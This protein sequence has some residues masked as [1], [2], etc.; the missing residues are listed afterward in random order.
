MPIYACLNRLILLLLLLLALPLKAETWP[1]IPG[2][3]LSVSYN[4]QTRTLSVYNHEPAPYSLKF[5]FPKLQNT[6]LSCTQPCLVLV[7]PMSTTA[8]IRLGPAGAGT[9]DFEYRYTSQI[10][11]YRAVPDLKYVYELPYTSGQSY[12]LSQGYNGPF[13]HQGPDRYALDFVMPEGT[14][15]LAAR[16]GTVVW[17]VSEYQLGG[18]DPKFK[19]HANSVWVL[20]SDGTLAQYAHLRHH[21]VSVKKGQQVQAGALLG[22]SGSTGYSTQPHLH[23]EVKRNQKGELETWPT[24]F[25]TLNGKALLQA[26]TRYQR[27]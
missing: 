21:G 14:P 10:G 19:G 20:H 7:P 2:P 24:L 8:V 9:W 15:V 17:T 4:R 26:Q 27:P 13:S 6:R 11:D 18:S 25:R 22:Y 3:E 5:S 16:A 12:W 23:F 1:Q